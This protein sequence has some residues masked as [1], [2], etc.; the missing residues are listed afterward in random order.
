MKV[1]KRTV[2]RLGARVQLAD[3]VLAFEALRMWMGY[4]I[5]HDPFLAWFFAAAL[6]GVAGLGWHYYLKLSAPGRKRSYAIDKAGGGRAVSTSR[7]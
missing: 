6:V 4:T 1:R 3:G 5:F 2:G 7:P